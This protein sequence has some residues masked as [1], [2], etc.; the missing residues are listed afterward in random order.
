MQLLTPDGQQMVDAIAARHGF[1]A[2][3]VQSLLFALAAGVADRPSSIIGNW[4]AW[5]NGLRV[6]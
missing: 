5:G 1:S 6:A 4:A 3:A 2:D